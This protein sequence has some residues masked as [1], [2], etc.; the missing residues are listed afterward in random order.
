MTRRGQGFVTIGICPT[1]RRSLLEKSFGASF[2]PYADGFSVIYGEV[3]FP[4][5][6]DPFK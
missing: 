6:N 1:L 5:A 4:S 2:V 3:A